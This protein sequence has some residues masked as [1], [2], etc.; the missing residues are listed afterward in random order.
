ML[1]CLQYSRLV[2]LGGNNFI[3]SGT[4]LQSTFKIKCAIVLK[5]RMGLLSSVF[6]TKNGI[7]RRQKT[8]GE[9]NETRRR[10]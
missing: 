8:D 7:G 1:L 3:I 2:L 10:L 9:S 4:L 6:V 5:P